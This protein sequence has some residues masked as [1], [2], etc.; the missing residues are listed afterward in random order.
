MVYHRESSI[1]STDINESF[2]PSMFDKLVNSGTSTY[3]N[4]PEV[5]EQIDGAFEE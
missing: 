1:F 4:K 5:I 2:I 3:N